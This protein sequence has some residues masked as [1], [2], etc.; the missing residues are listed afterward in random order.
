MDEN[1]KKPRKETDYQKQERICLNYAL[2]I[3]A[4]VLIGTLLL[5]IFNPFAT[6]G[7]TP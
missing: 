1:V 3:A 7:G 5:C 4:A 6:M 2:V